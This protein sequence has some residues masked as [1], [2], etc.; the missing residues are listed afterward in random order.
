MLPFDQT[1]KR[2]VV[3]RYCAGDQ[4]HVRIYVKGAPEYVI[5]LCTQTLDQN[6]T[7]IDQPLSEEDQFALL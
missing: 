3:V 5:G 7:K 2:K 4:E 6:G 1:L